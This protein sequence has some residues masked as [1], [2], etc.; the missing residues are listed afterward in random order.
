[1]DH[2]RFDHAQLL[3][4]DSRDPLQ[5]E[6]LFD[7]DLEHAIDPFDIGEPIGRALRRR[8]QIVNPRRL[9]QMEEAE[10]GDA[11][12]PEEERERAERQ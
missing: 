3:A 7:P 9:P 6:R 1:M 5:R 2:R 12:G 4:R 10:A 8:R 11:S